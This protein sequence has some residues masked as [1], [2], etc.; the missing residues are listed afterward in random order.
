MRRCAAI[1]SDQR[2]ILRGE[3]R[4]QGTEAPYYGL[5]DGPGEVRI[6]RLDL[7]ESDG[8]HS[9]RTSL[10]HL[11][12]CTDIH[13]VDVESPGRIEFVQR[14]YGLEA[15]GLLVPAYRPQELLNRHAW[16]AMV[17]SINTLDPS[18][19]TGAPV[20]LV[21]CSGDLTDNAQR[22][23]LDW[24]VRTMEGGTVIPRS[25]GTKYEGVGTL[26]WDDPHYWH[27]DEIPDAYKERWGFPALPGLQDEAIRPFSAGGCALPW[28]VAY[29]NHDA[30]VN[31][32]ALRTEAY[33]EILVGSRK[34]GRF[35]PDFDPLDHL[36]LYIENPE[37][38][39]T[40]PGRTVAPDPARRALSRRDF[41]KAHL[42]AGG[43]PA[44]H[45]FEEENREEGIAY[46]VWDAAA[47]MRVIVLD[48]T[49]P[50]GHYQG[51]VGAR[52]LAWLERRLAEV[53]SSFFAAD[54]RRIRT[55]NEDRLVVLI[56][57]HGLLTIN[58]P[59]VPYD[60]RDPADDDLPRSLGPELEALLHRFPN[61]ILWLNGHIHRNLILPRPDPARRAAGFWEVTT[62][63]LLDWPCQA[64]LVEIVRNADGTISVLCTMIDHD[65]PLSPEGG[66][67]VARLA[68][69]HRELAANDPHCG[70]GSGRQ[71]GPADRT[72]ELLIPAPIRLERLTV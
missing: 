12:H 14:Q 20:Q 52:Q 27:P 22:N 7:A 25:G 35:P 58:N 5:A 71:G 29:G 21:I 2:T 37:R 64:R 70:T 72:V 39:L 26:D 34:A 10:F 28:L 40:G 61:V 19:H 47:P 23:E 55:G 1:L 48:T 59:L 43:R 44:G 8:P 57:H 53:H 45:G 13:L 66:E 49:T 24:F 41:V 32:A 67:G 33:E 31:G 36:G 56:S 42:L 65:A 30:L 15:L 17:R 51:S 62:S 54:G 46:Y 68:S 11:V 18:A 9:R 16:E 38:F 4:G 6:K 60:P 3:P 50:G 63:S 69:I